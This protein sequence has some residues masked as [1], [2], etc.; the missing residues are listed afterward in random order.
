MIYDNAKYITFSFTFD[1]FIGFGVSNKN[2]L[3]IAS[4]INFDKK[5][6]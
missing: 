2:S 4:K 3:I 1:I 5:K 6:Y